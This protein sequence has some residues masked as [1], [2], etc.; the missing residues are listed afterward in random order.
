MKGMYTKDDLSL[1]MITSETSY[2][3]VYVDNY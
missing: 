1:D 3:W 2:V